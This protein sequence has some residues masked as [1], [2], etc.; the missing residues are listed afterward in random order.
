MDYSVIRKI[1]RDAF[2]LDK[3]DYEPAEVITVAHDTDRSFLH[4]G[5]F[6]SPIVDTTQEQLEKLGVH[7]VSIARIISTIKGDISFGNARSPEGGFARALLGKRL[8][9]LLKRGAYPFSNMEKSVWAAILDR[10]GAK[11]VIGMQPSRELCSAAHE[12]G[13]W[14]ADIQHGVIADQHPWYGESFRKD[15]PREQMP[16]AFMCWDRGSE[17]VTKHWAAKRGIATIPIG[18]RWLAR[19]LRP[20]AEDRLA[21]ELLARFDAE[22]ARLPPRRRTI[23]VSLSWGEYNIPNGFVIDPLERVIRRTSGEFRWLIRMHPNQL[24]GFATQEKARFIQYWKSTLKGHAEW[25]IATNYPLPVVLKNID[26]HISWSSSVCIEAAQSGVKSLLMDDRLRLPIY[27]R[28][29]EYY[30]G[31]GIVKLIDASES[32]IDEWIAE[33]AASRMEPE[34]YT[35][36]DNNYAAVLERLATR[37]PR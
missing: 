3:I 15:E 13:V 5:K 29:Y 20:A 28:Y 32:G 21:T 33:N 37:A 7:C 18:N 35:D 11:K 8:K 6:Y 36:F 9:G 30:R 1:A 14:V 27:D 17:I 10:T 12:R 16:D 31:L 34:D 22:A 26:M 4:E 2:R 19:F 25:E 23:L 24:K